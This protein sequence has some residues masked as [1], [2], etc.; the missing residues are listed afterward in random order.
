LGELLIRVLL[1]NDKEVRERRNRKRNEALAEVTRLDRAEDEGVLSQEGGQSHALA[2]EEE[3]RKLEVEWKV[4][5]SLVKS[6]SRDSNT[7][8]F[9]MMAS[10]RRRKNWIDRLVVNYTTFCDSAGR[11]GQSSGGFL[12]LRA[13]TA[14]SRVVRVG[15]GGRV[16]RCS[17]SVKSRRRVTTPERSSRRMRCG[18][19]FGA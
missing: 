6:G 5:P 2:Y 10:A 1:K 13:F 4:D 14:R 8:Y 9:H 16:R 17:A 18:R 12:L 3:D 11:G 19:R 15:G 7:R